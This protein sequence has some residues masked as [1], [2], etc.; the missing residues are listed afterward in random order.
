MAQPSILVVDDESS[1]LFTYRMI[2]EQ[3]GY[4]AT[5]ASTCGQAL[6]LL[7]KQRFD[8]LLCD[9]SLEENHTGFEVFDYARK[10]DPSVR[11]IL[12]TGYAS[13]EA[14]DRAER[15]GLS[16]LFKPIDIEEFLSTISNLVRDG[17]DQ[18][19]KSGT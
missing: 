5:A 3:Q 10:L 8:L 12:I 18:I 1:V 17:H 14:V 11:C 4:A 2:L 19:Q 9:L 15:E 7:D 6:Q 16:V 13:T